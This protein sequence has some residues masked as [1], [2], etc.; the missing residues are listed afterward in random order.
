MKIADRKRN[1]VN[2]KKGEKLWWQSIKNAQHMIEH[3]MYAMHTQAHTQTQTDI[4]Y[5]YED[6]CQIIYYSE[7]VSLLLL[8]NIIKQDTARSINYI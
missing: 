7:E 3:R 8:Q 2:G 6:K 5:C 4:E 1:G